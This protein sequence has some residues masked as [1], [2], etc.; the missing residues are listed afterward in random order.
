MHGRL[1]KG[2]V[3][4][5]VMLIVL[6]TSLA[7]AADGSVLTGLSPRQFKSMLERSGNDANVVLLDIR[8]PREF[9]SGHIAGAVL[10]D[11]YSSDFVDRLKALD[12]Q[13]TFLIYCRSG[14]RTGKSL[15]IF[16]KLGFKHVFH[17]EKGLI[18]WV[19]ENYPLV[20][21]AG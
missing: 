18:G 12:R 2:Y 20:S 9:A 5:S 14:N 10:I 6:I 16:E 8:T 1:S 3:A 17:L 15:A 19:S 13:K 11:Y 7:A 4:L 21:Q